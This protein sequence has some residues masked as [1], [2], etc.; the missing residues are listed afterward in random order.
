MTEAARNC[1]LRLDIAGVG[2]LVRRVFFFVAPRGRAHTK[3]IAEERRE[4]RE[5]VATKEVLSDAS[6]EGG[7]G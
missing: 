5:V 1:F 6:R 4:H 7:G 2:P 3:V